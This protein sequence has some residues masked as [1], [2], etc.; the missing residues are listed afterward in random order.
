MIIAIHTTRGGAGST[1][2]AA[3]ICKLAQ[4]QGVTVCAMSSDPA[5]ELRRWLDPLAI[6]CIGPEGDDSISATLLVIDVRTSSRPPIGPDIWVVPISDRLA[7][8]HA[9]QLSDGLMGEI[10]WLPVGGYELG[11][12]SVPAYLRDTVVIAPNVPYSRAIHISSA[13]QRVVWSIDGLEK[14][15][16][17]HALSRSLRTIFELAEVVP[18]VMPAPSERAIETSVVRA[19][20]A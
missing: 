8:E 20:Q 5:Q 2:I 16:G 7:Y 4:D 10:Y 3:H 15:P 11:P 12:E 13:Q 19:S 14:T 17:A 9:V 1:T 6:P 18:G